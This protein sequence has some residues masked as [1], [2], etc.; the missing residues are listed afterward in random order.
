MKEF[1]AS[2]WFKTLTGAA[3]CAGLYVL[4][5]AYP[6][7]AAKFA[8]LATMIAGALPSAFAGGA[9]DEAAP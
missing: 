1:L 6:M 9:K 7:Q 4:C 3:F 8:T 5:D 2:R